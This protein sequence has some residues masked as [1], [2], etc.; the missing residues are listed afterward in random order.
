ML[1]VCRALQGLGPAAFLLAGVM[2]MGSTYRPGPKKSLVFSLYGALSPVGFFAR[3]FPGGVS[4]QFLSWRWYFWIGAIV[5]FVTAP[6]ALLAAGGVAGQLEPGEGFSQPKHPLTSGSSHLY[7]GYSF[8]PKM[9]AV[10]SNFGPTFQ[11]TPKHSSSPKSASISLSW[12]PSVAAADAEIS[13]VA[14]N[15]GAK[16]KPA[17]FLNVPL[18]MSIPT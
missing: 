5:L 7:S 18:R 16:L 15:A 13:A 1:I 17:P 6:M 14:A 3:I 9:S 12:S 4:E 10:I 2:L 8:K 11:A